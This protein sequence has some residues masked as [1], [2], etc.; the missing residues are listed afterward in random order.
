MQ[1]SR[2]KVVKI[3][4]PIVVDGVE[5]DEVKVRVPTYGD[6]RRLQANHE[7]VD[8]SNYIVAGDF[9][10]RVTGLPVETLDNMAKVD[11]DKIDEAVN[12][13]LGITGS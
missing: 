10:S 3:D 6:F 5:T 7:F 9:L 11:V 1:Q 2:V 12:S 13:F 4:Y 8:F